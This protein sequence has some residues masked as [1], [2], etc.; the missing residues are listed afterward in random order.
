LKPSPNLPEL[1]V[2]A[3]AC[4]A[5]NRPLMVPTSAGIAISGARQRC[6]RGRA[7]ATI[8]DPRTP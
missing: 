1:Y 6:D 5:A 7:P 4:D 2:P 8:S 3:Y